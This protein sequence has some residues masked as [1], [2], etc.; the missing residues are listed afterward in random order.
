MNPEDQFVEGAKAHGWKSTS[1]YA[2]TTVWDPGDTYD[3]MDIQVFDGPGPYEVLYRKKQE[4]KRE[5]VLGTKLDDPN[6]HLPGVRARAGE[7]SKHPRK[8]AHRTA[9]A[10]AEVTASRSNAGKGARL[11]RNRQGTRP[12]I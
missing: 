4:I 11:G 6:G 3:K 12:S 7:D 2:S 10:D 1:G 9:K 8:P 5:T